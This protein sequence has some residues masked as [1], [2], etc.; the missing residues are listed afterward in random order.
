MPKDKNAPAETEEVN[1]SEVL[2]AEED[3]REPLDRMLTVL[4]DYGAQP[5]NVK[6]LARVCL[7]VAEEMIE[8]AVTNARENN[9]QEMAELRQ[10]FDREA[11]EAKELIAASRKEMAEANNHIREIQAKRDDL[12]AELKRSAEKYDTLQIAYEIKS[13][14][15]TKAEEIYNGACTAFETEIE[16]LKAALATSAEELA[17]EC[18]RRKIDA[19]TYVQA[20]NNQG[21]IIAD[22]DRT[23]ADI[24]TALDRSN[25]RMAELETKL[26]EAGHARRALCE[27]IETLANVIRN[28]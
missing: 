14:E 12:E 18:Q 13:V 17:K 22:R 15:L 11:E 28:D 16:E 7:A 6:T 3:T 25:R 9:R 4:S 21:S 19:E 26:N 23:I 5:S 20:V 8:E 1:M 2:L 27:A 24:N 10:N